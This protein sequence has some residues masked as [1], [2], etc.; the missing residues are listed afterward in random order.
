[1]SDKYV[2]EGFILLARFY[3]AYQ[4]IDFEGDLVEQKEVIKNQVGQF[5]IK[6]NKFYLI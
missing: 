1:M 2:D 5:F 4:I 6:L 3:N